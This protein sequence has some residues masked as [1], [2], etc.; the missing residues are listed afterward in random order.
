V[1]TPSATQV[2]RG[3]YRDGMAQWRG[4]AKHL[5]AVRDTLDPWIDFYGYPRDWDASDR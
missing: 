5:G 3:L 4:Y 2:A 1:R